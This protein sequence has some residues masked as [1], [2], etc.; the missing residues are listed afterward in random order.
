MSFFG[1]FGLDVM[2]PSF[3]RSTRT[4]YGRV[5]RR[6]RE[7]LLF[8]RED[9]GMYSR[10]FLKKKRRQKICLNLLIKKKRISQLI[11]GKPGENRYNNYQIRTTSKA[12]HSSASPIA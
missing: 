7:G 12:R 4:K 10:F 2:T 1:K 8:S 3:I 6:F 9:G 11:K 5:S